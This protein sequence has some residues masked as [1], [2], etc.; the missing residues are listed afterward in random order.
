MGLAY[1][2]VGKFELAIAELQKAIQLSDGQP[3]YVSA[4]GHIYASAGNQNDA[5]GIAERLVEISKERYVMPYWLAEI[6]ACMDQK[7]KAFHWLE[8]A[9]KDRSAWL[10]YTNIS[11]WLDN[12]RPDPRFDDLLQRMNFT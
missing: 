1:E 8:E 2:Q 10:V 11:P 7:D 9:Y 4:L 3:V 12:L 6:Y 5:R